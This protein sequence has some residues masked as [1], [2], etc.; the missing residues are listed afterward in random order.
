MIR[1]RCPNCDQ[2]LKVAAQHAGKKA[3][4]NKCA[5]AIQIPTSASVPAPKLTQT[6]KASIKLPSAIP[7][8]SE[9]TSTSPSHP[10]SD[11]QQSLDP[12]AERDLFGDLP[13]FAELEE[14]VPKASANRFADAMLPNLPDDAR[15]ESDNQNP[16]SESADTDT[17][18]PIDLA[19]AISS[20]E[21]LIQTDVQ[22]QE[23]RNAYEAGA[24]LTP[25]QVAKSFKTNVPAPERSE[26]F[27]SSLKT[28]A[29]AILI[30]P[31]VFALFVCIGTII[32][33]SVAIRYFSQP[34]DQFINPFFFFGFA[35]IALLL[36]AS[37]TPVFSMVG[38]VWSLF[39]SKRTKHPGTRTI[40]REEQ[41]TLYAF[42]DQICI[43]LDAPA[44]CRI[45]LDCEYNASASF[46]NGWSS[47]GKEEYVL[48]LGVPLIASQSAEQLASVIAHE[49]GHFC[50]TKAMRAHYAVR[51][52][53]GCF[54]QAAFEKTVRAEVTMYEMANS[55]DGG[56][57]L[58]AIVYYVGWIGRQMLWWFGYLGHKVSG[59][60][61]REMEYDADR[62]AVH[63]A[64]T[65]NFQR[66][67]IS[68]EKHGV[69]HSITIENLKM[70]F[71]DHQVFVNNIPRFMMHI[72]KTM[73]GA[74]VRKLANQIE[75]QKQDSFDTHPPTRDR[76]EAAEAF[77]QPSLIMMQRPAKDLIVNWQNLCEV[78]TLDFYRGVTG[79]DVNRT[80]VARL[81]DVLAAEH[82][83][84]LDK[85]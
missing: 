61:S 65:K 59:T 5:C 41:P 15:L 2:V 44:P 24:K 9:S 1:F 26:G 78:I 46:S 29:L 81:E 63:V 28:I 38:A 35:A 20:A 84:L 6:Q 51:H 69:A 56:S 27:G 58:Y 66:S 3:K 19:D 82:R 31:L 55:E 64:G 83:L 42:V 25:A 18:L 76:V 11:T 48:T 45:D 79:L 17:E 10:S 70:L 8:T 68:V 33:V 22:R 85:A 73:P 50:Q 23:K 37:W 49:F 52:I 4:C 80:H 67:M 14:A 12:P 62:Y 53:I 40:K 75:K 57:P 54:M 30:M 47:F 21:N 77:S 16:Q 39:F 7:P 71:C 72:A 43:Q 74:T 60:L 13:E 32:V 34:P 36:L